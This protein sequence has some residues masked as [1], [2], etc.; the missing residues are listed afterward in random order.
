MYRPQ[1]SARKRG[2]RRW[3]DACVQSLGSPT[4][5]KYT[6]NTEFVC[7]SRDFNRKVEGTKCIDINNWHL[8]KINWSCI[9]IISL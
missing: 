1:W 6:T 3:G 5:V 2:G 8:S 9:F 7:A 4:Q